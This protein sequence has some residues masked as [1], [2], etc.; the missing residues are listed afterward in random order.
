MGCKIYHG[1]YVS[2]FKDIYKFL[3]DKNLSQEISTISDLSNNLIDD[4][5]LRKNLNQSKELF[6]KIGET[7]L[8]KTFKEID[9]FLHYENL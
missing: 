9:K 1:P 3:M 8:I 7:I 6:D 4:F 2:N 5:K